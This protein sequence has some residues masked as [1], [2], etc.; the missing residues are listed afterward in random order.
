MPLFSHRKGL[1]PTGKPLQIDDID[2]DL[3]N[4][5]WNVFDSVYLLDARPVQHFGVTEN[6]QFDNL[7]VDIWHNFFKVP[8][9]TLSDYRP[10]NIDSLRKWFFAAK[11][12]EVYDFIEFVTEAHPDESRNKKFIERCNTVLEE[13]SAGYRFVSGLITDITS[14][15]EIQEVQNAQSSPIAP[16]SNHFRRAL[17]LQIDRKKPDYRNSVKESVLALEA[18]FKILTGKPNSTLGEALKS[19]DPKADVH[20]TLTKAFSS[21]YGYTS[22]AEGIR[23]ALLDKDNVKQEDARYFLITC[24]AFANYMIAKA[25]RAGIRLTK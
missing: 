19:V 2:D 13:E 18:L 11:W 23:H 8:I 7:L 20:P 12:N 14:E 24:S 5:L 15:T 22:S 9:D 4:R 21:L 17:E 10:S 1:K 16:M 3:K 6:R 25:A